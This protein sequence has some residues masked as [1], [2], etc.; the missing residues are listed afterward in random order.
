MQNLNDLQLASLLEEIA[1]SMSVDKPIIDAMKRLRGRRLGPVARAANHI[2]EKI[3]RGGTPAD[4]IRLNESASISQASAALASCQRSGD[5]KMLTQFAQQ[6]RQ[7][8][9]H[10]RLLRLTWLYPI[11]LLVVA[12]AVGVIVMAPLIRNNHGRSFQWSQW[13]HD[14]SNWV[15]YSWW[16]PPVIAFVLLA[17]LLAVIY[18]RRRMPKDVRMMLFCGSLADQIEQGAPEAEAIRS[19]ALMAGENELAEQT[20]QT[21][22]SPRV[23]AILADAQLTLPD[24]VDAKNILVESLRY[25]AAVHSEDAKNIDYFWGQFLPRF[26]MVFIGGG[27]TIAYAWWVI[28]PIY[29]QVGQW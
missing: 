12:Y 16:I 29:Q 4:A 17:G 20:D 1:A 7:R 28:R 15:V 14:L 27:L 21:L 5:P 8:H 9:Q 23:K 3:D 26:A 6:L 22:Q 11:L 19:A 10:S 18:S 24:N 2:A 25:K 13:V